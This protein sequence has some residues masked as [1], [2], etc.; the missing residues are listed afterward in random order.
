MFI[1]KTAGKTGTIILSDDIAQIVHTVPRICELTQ[2]NY[3]FWCLSTSSRARPL[4]GDIETPL[5]KHGEHRLTQMFPRGRVV[6]PTPSFIVTRPQEFCRLM[7]WFSAEYRRPGYLLVV[8]RDFSAWLSGLIEQ[9]CVAKD[10][11]EKRFPSHD[12]RLRQELESQ[13]LEHW[14]IQCLVK[15]RNI[16]YSMRQG[17]DDISDEGD[18][19]GIRVAN[20][21]CSPSDEQSLVNS[22]LCFAQTQADSHRYFYVVGSHGDDRSR[23]YLR[24][25]IP[26]YIPSQTLDAN[27]SAHELDKA[28]ELKATS[29]YESW[30]RFMVGRNVNMDGYSPEFP[31]VSDMAQG[32]PRPMPH[33]MFTAD[34]LPDIYAW[35]RSLDKTRT[36][37]YGYT[38][39]H[40]EPITWNGRADTAAD[41]DGI[42]SSLSAWLDQCP[43]FTRTRNTHLGLFCTMDGTIAAPNQAGTQLY[44]SWIAVYR[45]L[46]PHKYPHDDASELLIWDPEIPQSTEEALDL[47][48]LCD[49]Q[50][51]LV[52]LIE[53]ASP[54]RIAQCRLT[55]IWISNAMP[56]DADEQSDPLDLTC[57]QFHDFVEET[58]F[59]LPPTG[60]LLL[61]RSW[62]MLDLGRSRAV[63]QAEPSEE[64][65]QL[66]KQPFPKIDSDDAESWSEHDDVAM[67]YPPGRGHTD[68]VWPKRSRATNYMYEEAYKARLK[69]PTCTSFELLYPATLDWYHKLKK[70]GR[71]SAQVW[72]DSWRGIFP[73][74]KNMDQVK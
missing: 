6:C 19:T 59:W 18:A 2:K 22:F 30:K 56:K 26:D 43:T 40:P 54:S 27:E 1:D 3:S 60:T 13:G 48:Q 51:A 17:F 49:A 31:P 10:K 50:K 24:V 12:P 21:V 14:D 66:F 55:R 38:N 11:L 37:Q 5:M 64:R 68:Q 36:F 32:N 67:V 20:V 25:Q 71:H 35:L 4:F 33:G 47:S 57:H 44:R 23:A 52:E 39:M 41:S 65:S 70:E 72:V 62:K 28:R 42:T 15:A 73:K 7:K 69:D 74:L 45:P 63:T 58:P 34:K 16:F 8:P 53:T 61:E 29:L 9:K 46:R